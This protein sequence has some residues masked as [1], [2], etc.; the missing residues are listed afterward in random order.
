MTEGTEFYMAV[1]LVSSN[2]TDLKRITITASSSTTGTLYVPHLNLTQAFSVHQYGSV[3]YDLPLDVLAT[4]GVEDKGISITSI[5]PI[6]IQFTVTS[7][8]HVDVV[9]ILKFVDYSKQFMLVTGNHTSQES[10][11]LVSIIATQDN[12]Q[13]KIKQ[14]HGSGN[15]Y[16]ILDNVML[17]RL[18]VFTKRLESTSPI[19]FTGLMVDADKP[20][21]VIGGSTSKQGVHSNTNCNIMLI[22]YP[23]VNAYAKEHYSYPI[24]KG[25][26]HHFYHLRV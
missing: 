7:A 21:N 26:F 20:V 2:S 1:P 12:T 8:D 11:N 25:L 13:V 18:Q 15:S 24:G 6:S 5:G 14:F 10:E 22:N 19:D 3:T 17:N 4:S 9:R 23:T 16:S